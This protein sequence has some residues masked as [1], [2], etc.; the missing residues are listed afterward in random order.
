M[1][2]QTKEQPKGI[3]IQALL[4]AGVHFG[5]QRYR[6][7]PKMDRFI[8]EERNGI[9]ILD[10][11]KTIR[12]MDRA[13]AVLEKTVQERKT[14]LFVGTKKSA[15][16]FVQQ[17]AEECGEF[18]VSER[19]LG[20]MLTNLSTIRASIK[21]LEKIEKKIA[22]GGEGLLKKEVEKLTKQYHKLQKYLSGIRSMRKPPGLLVIVDPVKERIAVDEARKLGIPV[23]AIIDSNGDPDLIDYPIVG[24]D[25]A[26]KSVKIL[27]KTLKEAIV[28]KKEALDIPVARGEKPIIS[29]TAKAPKKESKI[30]EEENE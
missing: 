18:S 14:I 6:W 29:P 16:L 15:K 22:S 21:K 19:W 27:L 17:Y 10:L 30:L 3:S 23:M 4:E 1:G 11:S 13:I 7:N 5:H 2:A 9:H 28:A 25:D 20:G 12:Q 24:N 26:Q 8:F